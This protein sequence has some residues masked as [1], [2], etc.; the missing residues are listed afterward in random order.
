MKKLKLGVLE[1]IS[2]SHNNLRTKTMQGLFKEFPKVGSSLCIF[3][4]GIDFGNRMILTSPV[5]EILDEGRDQDDL[6]YIIFK[7]AN[8]KY[9]LTIIEDEEVDSVNYLDEVYKIPESS[10]GIQ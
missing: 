10:A 7:T 1:K 5:A 8:S 2:S 9:R 3:G 4:E 6:E